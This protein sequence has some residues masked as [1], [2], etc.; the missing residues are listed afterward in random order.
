M[1]LD[2]KSWRVRQSGSSIQSS[3]VQSIPFQSNPIQA[4]CVQRRQRDSIRLSGRVAL[5]GI[6]HST[7]SLALTHTYTH[8]RSLARSQFT[9]GH[10]RRSGVRRLCTVSSNL[11]PLAGSSEIHARL[12]TD[13]GEPSHIRS[14]L[15]VVNPETKRV[16]VS[17]Q[18]ELVAR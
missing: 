7:L 6:G 8:S 17:V 11:F 9:S 5:G 13:R 16:R 14:R 15:V 12:P 10:H 1:R 3:P 2:V 4:S 18:R